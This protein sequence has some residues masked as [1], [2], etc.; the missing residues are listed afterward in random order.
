LDSINNKSVEFFLSQ[1]SEKD[2]DLHTKGIP[3]DNGHQTTSSSNGK[4][5]LKQ[6]VVTKEMKLYIKK[7]REEDQKTIKELANEVKRLTKLIP[8]KLIEE[9]EKNELPSEEMEDEQSENRPE[10]DSG[11]LEQN[12]LADGATVSVSYKDGDLQTSPSRSYSFWQVI[13]SFSVGALFMLLWL[14]RYLP[15]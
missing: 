2:D 1:M 11:M 10:L 3:S 7:L 5:N 12:K 14:W 4:D 9:D 8:R 15:T 13:C 6:S